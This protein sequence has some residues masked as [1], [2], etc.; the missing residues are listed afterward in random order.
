M[1]TVNC[2]RHLSRS[3]VHACLLCVFTLWG[4]CPGAVARDASPRG[5]VNTLASQ[6][7]FCSA[8]YDV[9]ECGRRI[10]QLKAV[11]T[12]SGAGAPKGWRW[13]I[14]RSEDWQPLVK[15]VHLDRESP[16]FTGITEHETFL[17]D[18]LFFAQPARTDELVRHF[19]TPFNRLLAFAVSHELGHAIC[20]NVSEAVANRVAE[21]LRGGKGPNCDGNVKSLTPAEEWYLR[22]QIPGFRHF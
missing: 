10:A 17:E 9:H 13:V 1:T 6:E 22:T 16:A 18:A 4:T 7:F 8:G 21:Q 2:F 11:L 15:S 5:E 19:R 14:V 3:T 20:H 12:E